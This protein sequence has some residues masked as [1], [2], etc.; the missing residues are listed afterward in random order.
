MRRRLNGCLSAAVL[1]VIS[2][3][4]YG[5]QPEFLGLGFTRA[6]G[7]SGDGTTVVGQNGSLAVRWRVGTGIE[8]LGNL[9]GSLNKAKGVSRN[10]SVITGYSRLGGSEYHAFRWTEALGMTDLDDLPGG[11]H[12]S[13]GMSGVSD[14]GSVIIGS[15]TSTSGTEAFRWTSS[16]GITGLEDLAGGNFYSSARNCPPDGSIVVGVSI[17]GSY[18][19][20][21][22]TYEPFL[23]TAAEGM[24]GLGQLVGGRPGG[25]AY[26]V[27]ADGSIVV[28]AGAPLSGNE[29]AFV[30]TPQ[31]GAM[32]GLGDFEGGGMYS[33]AFAIT[34]DG[35]TIVG[36]GSSYI[37][38]EAFIY[39]TEHGMRKFRDV[40]TSEYGLDLNGWILRDASG[41]SDDGTVLVGYGLNPAGDTEAWMAVI[42]E[43]ATLSLLGVGA[44]AMLRRR[45]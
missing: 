40:L 18:G 30:W 4:A 13:R 29:E 35:S 6:Y 41:I 21:Y 36:R 34:P 23:W 10:G 3:G 31:T 45:K 28:G 44:L 42:P 26:D 37:G 2:F 12:S 38:E 24:V 43:P 8:D 20:G 15:G 11:E 33:R 7:I 39:D 1:L 25:S 16:E 27:S 32:V 14:D 17:S 22:D 5:Q 19:G 9:G